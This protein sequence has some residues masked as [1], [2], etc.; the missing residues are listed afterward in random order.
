MAFILV[1]K[2]TVVVGKEEWAIDS[3]RVNELIEKRQESSPDNSFSAVD[4]PAFKASVVVPEKSEE[5]VAWDKVKDDPTQAIK[6]IAKKL[7]LE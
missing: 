5:G 4:E 3:E 2:G 1:K 7:G 6:F